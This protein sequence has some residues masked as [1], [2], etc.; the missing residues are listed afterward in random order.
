[1]RTTVRLP[2]DLYRRVRVSAAQEGETVTSFL[3]EALRAALARR[4]QAPAD[5]RYRVTAFPGDGV[6]P[7]VDLDDSSALLDLMDGD[8]RA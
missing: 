7:G 3:E 2:D 1:M 8:A 6:R 4:E 5:T